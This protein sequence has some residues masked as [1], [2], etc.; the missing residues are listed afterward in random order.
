M[1]GL[2][3]LGTGNSFLARLISSFGAGQIVGV[4]EHE[5]RT[6]VDVITA[7]RAL[8][9]LVEGKHCGIFHLAGTTQV[10]RLELNRIIARRFGFPLDQVVAQPAAGRRAPR[11]R[12][13]SMSINRTRTELKTPMLSLEDGLSLIINNRHSGQSHPND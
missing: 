9:E 8:L 4:P 2:P 3:L 5:V 13:V 1:A 10:N 11:P 7:G 6:P 12:D